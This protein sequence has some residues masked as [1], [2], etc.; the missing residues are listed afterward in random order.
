MPFYIDYW[1]SSKNMTSRKHRYAI[2]LGNDL[3]ISR[4]LLL[5]KM[6]IRCA[7][8]AMCPF[9]SRPC[10]QIQI[11]DMI[12]DS[13]RCRSVCTGEAEQV[14]FPCPLSLL[15]RLECSFMSLHRVAAECDDPIEAIF[16]DTVN[17]V[18]YCYK[19]SKFICSSFDPSTC[20]LIGAY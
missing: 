10:S 9:T 8:A 12:S 5:G 20:P 1:T 11:I 16:S 3:R 17:F 2:P 13:D 15:T 19:L 14:L 7:T 18:E 4:V 6:C